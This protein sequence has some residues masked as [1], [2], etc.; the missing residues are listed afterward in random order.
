MSN[1]SF[2]QTGYPKKIVHEG[3]TVIAITRD[4]MKKVNGV[5]LSLQEC[6]EINDSV[7]VVVDSC[8]AAFNVFRAAEKEL[9]ERISIRD[10]AIAERNKVITEAKDLVKVQKKEIRRLRTHRTILGIS[11]G[12]LIAVTVYLLILL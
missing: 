6:R 3:D 12:A 2:S 5:Q 1:Y 9:K 4:Q 7:M 11:S 8:G 10:E